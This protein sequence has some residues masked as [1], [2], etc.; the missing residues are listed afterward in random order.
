MLRACLNIL[1]SLRLTVACLILA[2]ILVF[3]GT[4]A[5]VWMGLYQAQAEIFRSFFVHWTPAGTHLRIPVFPG[6]WLI[7]LTLLVNLVAAHIKRFRF[8]RKKTGILLI[9]AGLILLLL[10]QFLTEVYQVESQMLLDVGGS[11]N[12]TE[13]SRRHELAVLDVTDPG[14]DNVTTIP[15]SLLVPGTEIR[16]SGLPFTLR[17][18]TYFKNSE[19]AIPMDPSE[20]IKASRGIGQTLLLASAPEVKTMDDEDKPA[21]LVEVVSNNASLGD[22]TE[23][24]WFT[25]RQPVMLLQD[26][27]AGVE[28]QAGVKMGVSPEDPQSFTVAGRTYQMALRMKRYYKPYTIALLEFK[29]DLYQGTDIPKNFSSRI[30]LSDPARGEDRDVLIHMNAPLRY[31]GETFYQA[32]FLSGDQASILQVVRNPAAVTPY[33]ACSLVALGLV[34]QFLTHLFGFAKKQAQKAAQEIP[35][36]PPAAAVLQPAV[37]GKRSRV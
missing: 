16:A 1:T 7:G 3:L 17:V 12:Y 21:A 31:R 13:D 4:L 15:E 22:W 8:E 27:I 34:V 23:S 37:A 35:R 28:Q 14:R 11:K 18:K 30:H 24:L 25:K 26:W 33:L 5:E 36:R 2:I 20:K 10:G 6:G 9:H 32:S 29:H 19:P